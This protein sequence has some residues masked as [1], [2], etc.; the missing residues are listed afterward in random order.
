MQ[1][2]PVVQVNVDSSPSPLLWTVGSKSFRVQ[3]R[4]LIKKAGSWVPLSEP[5]IPWVQGG[6]PDSALLIRIPR[7]FSCRQTQNEF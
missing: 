3:H 5:F 6:V 4:M 1:R 2:L 7:G